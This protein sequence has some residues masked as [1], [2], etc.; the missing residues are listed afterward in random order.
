VIREEVNDMILAP[1]HSLERSDYLVA[2][3]EDPA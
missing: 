3:D 2:L 1:I